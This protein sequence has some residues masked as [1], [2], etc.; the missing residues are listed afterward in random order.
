MISLQCSAAQGPGSG[1]V[2]LVLRTWLSQPHAHGTPF[3]SISFL[4]AAVRRSPAAAAAAA[5]T[6]RKAT[7]A[8]KRP[9]ARTVASAALAGRL[10]AAPQR[11]PRQGDPAAWGQGQAA[12]PREGHAGPLP[13]GATPAR[14]VG[15]AR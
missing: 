1:V 3:A 6:P 15:R 8:A 7:E 10:A 13:L 5:A 4:W 11:P 12:D 2:L 9:P 14:E